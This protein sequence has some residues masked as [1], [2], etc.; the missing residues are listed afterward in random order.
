MSLFHTMRS[1]YN[2]RKENGQMTDNTTAKKNIEKPTKNNRT[3]SQ[4]QES[5]QRTTYYGISF[6][7]EGI[8]FYRRW[9]SV[10]LSVTMITKKIVDVF[11]QN[12]MGG[13]LGGKEDQVHVSLRS[14]EGC[15]SNGQKTP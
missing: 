13:F 7:I 11:V 10:C 4:L 14:V 6:I 2:N 3:T 8:C 5:L 12:F 1:I 15:G 9:L